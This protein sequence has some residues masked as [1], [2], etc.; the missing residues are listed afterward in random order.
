[1]VDDRAPL[2]LSHTLE[3]IGHFRSIVGSEDASQLGA[4]LT[5][6]YAAERCVEII[7]EA[8]RRVPAGW[9]AEHASVPWQNIASIGSVL[10]HD[11]ENVNIEIIIKLRGRPL[12]DLKTAV[13]ALLRKY[14]LDFHQP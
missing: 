6:R 2:A 3:A 5:R 10:R 7:S 4:D 14:D 1:M 9:K 12:E 11:Y 13:L 8:S